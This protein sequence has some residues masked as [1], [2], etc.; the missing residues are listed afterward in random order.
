MKI[1]PLKMKSLPLKNDAY[2]KSIRSIVVVGPNADAPRFGDLF[3]NFR[4]EMQKLRRIYPE[5]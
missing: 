2:S 3:L 4:L 1:F 5:K